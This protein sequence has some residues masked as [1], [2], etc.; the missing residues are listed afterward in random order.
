MNE[1]V[2]SK[3]ALVRLFGFNP[4]PDDPT[5]PHG[6]GGPVV[7]NTILDRIAWALLNPQPLPPRS[8]AVSRIGTMPDPWRSARLARAVIDQATREMQIADIAGRAEQGSQSAQRG[9]AEFIDDF[10]GTRVPGRPRPPHWVTAAETPED[11]LTAAAQ[12]QM[13]ADGLNIGTPLQ[14]ACAA[15][16]EKLF[17]TGLR[18]L[19]TLQ[20][21]A[22]SG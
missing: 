9:I 21:K 17:E 5:E 13:A 8:A 2:F 22:A 14:T 1:L 16:A 11:L 15:A 7:R 12:F 4:N 10:C 18:E 19:D 20:T 6:P 3:A